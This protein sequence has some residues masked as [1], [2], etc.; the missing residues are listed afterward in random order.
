ME[1]IDIQENIYHFTRLETAMLHILPTMQ[2]KLS[3][4]LESN[5]PKENKSFGFWSILE[6]FN[7]KERIRVK[8]QFE[9]F[10]KSKCKQLCFS[11]SYF[12][13]E[14]F[15]KGFNHP[16]MWAHYGENQ[17]GVCIVLNR[18]KFKNSN[19]SLM[20]DE[21]G[22]LPSFQFPKLMKD[23]PDNNDKIFEEY[24]RENKKEMFFT[25]HYHWGCEHEYKFVEIGNLDYCSIRD[26]LV[27]IFVGNSFPEK[28][29]KCLFD[30]VPDYK[31]KKIVFQDGYFGAI[32]LSR[33]MV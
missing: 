3:P 28:F 22:Y 25:K 19:P 12:I 14:T 16:S 7:D 24:L 23:N 26:S 18:E 10:L 20:Y 11:L 27:G 9:S 4:F 2:L 31:V 15:V 29:V 33:S 6:H 1:S 5:D 30:L 32:P 13:G 21:V 17:K 8:K